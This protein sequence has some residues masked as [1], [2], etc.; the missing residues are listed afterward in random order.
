MRN[1]HFP[2]CQAV[3]RDIA[4]GNIVLSQQWEAYA[5]ACLQPAYDYFTSHFLHGDLQPAVQVFK[6]ARFFNPGKVSEIQPT[7][8]EVRD[9]LTKIPFL[10]TDACINDFQRELPAYIAAAEGVRPDIEVTTWWSHHERELPNWA[11][12]CRKVLLMQPSSAASERVFSLLENSFHAN[13]ARAM[14]DYIEASLML[15]YNK[16]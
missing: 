7:A 16:R 12:A 14:E 13:Q 1:Q 6:A 8:A 9:Q 4:G 10:N 5:L 2:S 11:A 15:Q 3:I